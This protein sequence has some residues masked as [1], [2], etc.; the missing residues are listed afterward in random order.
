MDAMQPVEQDRHVTQTC[1]AA[2][3]KAKWLNTRNVLIALAL[4]AAALYLGWDWL[5]AVGAASVIL[6]VLPC[7]AM[8]ALGLCMGRKKDARS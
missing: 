5:V 3:T 8:C 6:A 4:I 2:P 7:L 1:A